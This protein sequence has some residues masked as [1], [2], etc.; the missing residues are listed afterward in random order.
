MR[1]PFGFLVPHAYWWVLGAVVVGT[2]AGTLLRSAARV[3]TDGLMEIPG[4]KWQRAG[5]KEEMDRLVQSWGEAG[6][7]AARNMLLWDL[8]YLAAYGFLLT[9]LASVGSSYLRRSGSSAAATVWAWAAWVGL[10]AP[11]LDVV[12]NALLWRMLHPFEG[13]A[14]PRA[15][16][17]ASKLKWT[18]GI[19]VALLFALPGLMF[20]LAGCRF[21]C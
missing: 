11:A 3:T 1:G 19:G 8:G 14:L 20:D 9:L 17:I 7:R 6:R 21:G 4:M 15:M 12:E 13:E 5:T 10:A 18:I 2:V 16:A